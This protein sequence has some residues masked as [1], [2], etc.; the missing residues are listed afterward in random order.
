MLHRIALRVLPSLTTAVTAPD[1]R[2]R[3]RFV[4]LVPGFVASFIY[5]ALKHADVLSSLPVVL[6]ACGLLASLTALAAFR[7]GRA[8]PFAAVWQEERQRLPWLL[9]WIGIAYGIQLALLVFAILKL[10]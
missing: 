8:I 10:V 5:L 4:M 9:G 2:R 3:K 6:S 1:V 7:V